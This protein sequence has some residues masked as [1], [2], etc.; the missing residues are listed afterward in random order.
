MDVINIF[1]RR[2]AF[3]KLAETPVFKAWHKAEVARQL[4]RLSEKG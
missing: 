4:W 2:A 3:E 1:N